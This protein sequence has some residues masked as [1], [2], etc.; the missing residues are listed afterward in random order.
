MTFPS[1]LSLHQ[2]TKLLQHSHLVHNSHPHNFQLEGLLAY[3]SARSKALSTTSPNTFQTGVSKVDDALPHS[4]SHFS[5]LWA[6]CRVWLGIW[7]VAMWQRSPSLACFLP[8]LHSL[9]LSP[10]RV[11]WVVGNQPHS[12][13]RFPVPVRECSHWQRR[14]SGE[15]Q[16]IVENKTICKYNWMWNKS[17]L[18]WK[19]THS[20]EPDLADRIILSLGLGSRRSTSIVSDILVIYG[21]RIHISNQTRLSR[22]TEQICHQFTEL[23]T[24]YVK[25]N[26]LCLY[27]PNSGFGT[28]NA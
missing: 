12:C 26:Y 7:P 17:V 20:G 2:C 8:P 18:L 4:S 25:S 16:D 13:A 9:W 19:L 3:K 22:D 14:I 23:T 10:Q 5:S 1:E 21:D 24:R 6:H 15:C 11:E 27:I 28:G